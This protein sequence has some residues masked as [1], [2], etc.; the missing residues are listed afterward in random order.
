[1]TQT[2]PPPKKAPTKPLP[3]ID[4]LSRPFWEAAAQHQLQLQ[5]CQECG[6]YNHP[7]RLACDV[8]QSQQ[9]AFVPV[10]GRGHIY[11]FTVMYQPNVAGFEQD[12]P[13]INLLIEL[14]E[15]PRLFLTAF[16]PGSE[17]QNIQIGDPVE[18]YFQPVNEEIILPQFRVVRR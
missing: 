16:L 18:V 8:C 1:M 5:Q 15:Q 2:T 9:F 7:P 13:Y 3:L 17:Q 10:S 14:E 6:S 11:S 4:D 12:L